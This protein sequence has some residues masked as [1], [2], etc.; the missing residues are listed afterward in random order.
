LVLIKQTQIEVLRQNPY[1]RFE[2]LT[3]D[4]HGKFIAD[5]KV[6]IVRGTLNPECLTLINDFDMNLRN[7][8][9]AYTTASLKKQFERF[10]TRLYKDKKIDTVF[11]PHSF[12]HYA[13]V[14]FYKET[15]DIFATMK[16]LNHQNITT[17][18]I[19]LKGF[20]ALE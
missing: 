7:P 13:A 19:Y 10:L 6:N 4:K 20:G 8:F 17:T 2:S 11:S 3:I 5:S 1:I 16:F 15:F 12:R 9:K 18:Q 14:K